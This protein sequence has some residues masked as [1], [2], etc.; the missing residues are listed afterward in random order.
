MDR[1]RVREERKSRERSAA[2]PTT[3]EIDRTLRVGCCHEPGRIDFMGALLCERH[4]EEL[5]A[6]RC[7]NLWLAIVYQLDT[8][9]KSADVGTREELARRVQAQR[10]K[11]VAGLELVRKGSD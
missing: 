10:E 6:E 9:L 2:E 7:E 8:W 3:C 4:A 11:A 5:M 1:N